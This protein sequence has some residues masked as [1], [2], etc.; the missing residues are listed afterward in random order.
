MI[1]LK[2]GAKGELVIP[3]KIRES[4]GMSREKKIVLEV[5]GKTII[6]RSSADDIVKR[7]EERAKKYNWDPKDVLYGDKLYE[8]IF[9]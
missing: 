8:E 4:L 7:C 6:L 1:Q 9:S 2:L 3:K 5:K